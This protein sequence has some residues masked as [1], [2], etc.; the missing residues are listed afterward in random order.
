M[1]ETKDKLQEL[2]DIKDDNTG[3]LRM[4]FENFVKPGVVVK[5]REVAPGFTVKLKALS[6][7][8]LMQAE[9]LVYGAQGVP[10]DIVVKVR[11]ASI[12]SQSILSVNGIDIEQGENEKD[13]R[14][15]RSFLYKKLLDMPPYVVQQAY[16]LYI[17]AVRDQNN[18][19][20]NKDHET[21]EK[22]E[23]F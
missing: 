6:T 13:N 20:Q 11:S 22:I 16:E 9:S 15:R 7:G 5:E 17:E 1:P 14:V 19:Y 4:F 21:E 8:E 12:L 23:N 2:A 18:I 10:N 3:D